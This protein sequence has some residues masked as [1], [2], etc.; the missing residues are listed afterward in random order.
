MM[1]LL[2]SR[3]IANEAWFGLFNCTLLAAFFYVTWNNKR[4]LLLV[5]RTQGKMDMVY[6]KLTALKDV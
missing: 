4:R 2:I 5:E 3:R 6:F 1:I